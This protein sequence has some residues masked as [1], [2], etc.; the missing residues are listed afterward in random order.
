LLGLICLLGME[1]WRTLGDRAGYF[2]APTVVRDIEDGRELVDQEQFS[3]ILPVVRI[4]SAEDGFV[5]A[6][7]CDYGL[8]GSILISQLYHLHGTLFAADWECEGESGA[9]MHSMRK[10]IL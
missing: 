7:R 8:C 10:R 9:V 2:V 5:R 6:N 4:K 3:P 1:R